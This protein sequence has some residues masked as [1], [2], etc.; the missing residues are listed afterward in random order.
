M[1]VVTLDE[2]KAIK[3]LDTGER[4]EHLLDHVIIPS[5]KAKQSE[6]YINFINVL[7]NS[8]DSSLKTV[9]AQLIV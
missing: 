4:M 2:K 5:L 3:K 1:K 7:K 8:D 9:A 6:K